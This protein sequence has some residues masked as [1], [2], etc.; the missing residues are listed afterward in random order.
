MLSEKSEFDLILNLVDFILKKNM[1]I[2][3]KS[4]TVSERKI[5]RLGSTYKKSSI[6][7]RLR[8]VLFLLLLHA[9][10]ANRP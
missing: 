4:T 6:L 3:F 10:G 9:A 8:I 5:A 7:G 2:L 1:Q